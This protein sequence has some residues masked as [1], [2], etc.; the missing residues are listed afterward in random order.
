VLL[1]LVQVQVLVH[2]HEPLVDSRPLVGRRRTAETNSRLLPQRQQLAC[3]ALHATRPQ[4]IS[5]ALTDSPVGLLAWMAE[6]F[7]EWTDPGR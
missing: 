1:H 6:K 5:Y 4:T 2:C 3:Q 7:T